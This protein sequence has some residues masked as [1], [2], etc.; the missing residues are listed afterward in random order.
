V[1]V[2]NGVCRRERVAVAT[3]VVTNNMTV[4][5]DFCQCQ[6]NLKGESRLLLTCRTLNINKDE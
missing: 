3:V 6:L 4:C 2:E 5:Y 1:Y